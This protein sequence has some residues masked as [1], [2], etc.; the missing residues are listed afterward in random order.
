MIFFNELKRRKRR[1]CVCVTYES[2]WMNFARVRLETTSKKLAE[3]L[4]V[5]DVVDVDLV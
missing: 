5:C 1:G 2:G 4:V 3:I